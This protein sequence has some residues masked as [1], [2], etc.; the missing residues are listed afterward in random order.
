MKKIVIIAGALLAGSQVHA[1]ATSD[2][3]IS[4][5]WNSLAI[6]GPLGSLATFTDPFTGETLSSDAEGWVGSDAIELD[7]AYTINGVSAIASYSDS[8]LNLT[9]GFDSS[10]NESGGSVFVTNSDAGYESG[11]AGSWNGYIYQ[12]SGTGAVT[13]SV[14]YSLLGSV[15]TS[16]SGEY[17]NGGYDLFMDAVDADLWTSTYNATFAASGDVLAA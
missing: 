16:A 17:A 14:N 10:T 4:I 9:G 15:S 1:T 11:W 13:V 8:N 7:S 3:N 12:A 2:M 6:T 5:D